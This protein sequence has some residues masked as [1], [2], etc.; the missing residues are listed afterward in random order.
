[1]GVG[2]VGLKADKLDVSAFIPVGMGVKIKI[3]ERF[4]V[5]CEWS[6]R[7]TF[8]DQLDYSDYGGDFQLSDP[9]LVESAQNKNKDWY[10]IL[11]LNVSVD[12]F[13]TGSNCYK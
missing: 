11:T 6:F 12:L 3:F 7:K 10:S 9:W 13:G 5:G 1:L 2:A 4:N 8:T